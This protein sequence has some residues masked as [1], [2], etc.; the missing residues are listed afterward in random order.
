MTAFVRFAGAPTLAV[1]LG[2][3]LTGCS[4][5]DDGKSPAAGT[6]VIETF[7]N[8]AETEFQQRG[9]GTFFDTGFLSYCRQNTG[10]DSGVF[11]ALGYADSNAPKNVELCY[12]VSD[13]LKKVALGAT[14]SKGDLQ[15]V[16]LDASSGSIVRTTKSSGSCTP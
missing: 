10:F 14:S 3:V 15:C 4:D 16:V 6:S 9:Q 8:R 13:D 2:F 7:A 12:N 5:G 1:I 11:H